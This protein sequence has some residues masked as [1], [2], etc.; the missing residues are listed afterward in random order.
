M[1]MKILRDSIPKPVFPSLNNRGTQWGKAG[2]ASMQ[3]TPNSQVPLPQSVWQCPSGC[4]T[5][6]LSPF[7]GNLSLVIHIA[8]VPKYHL[9]DICRGMLEVEGQTGEMRGVV[10]LA[11]RPPNSQNQCWGQ[12]C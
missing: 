11:H 7:L 12:D 9:F 2:L 8:L 4:H 5:H 1:L 6:L 3:E 10:R